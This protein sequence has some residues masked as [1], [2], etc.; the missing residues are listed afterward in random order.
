MKRKTDYLS[1]K[2]TKNISRKIKMKVSHLLNKDF[3]EMVIRMLTKLESGL[4]ELR[5][6]FNKDLLSVIKNQTN[7]KNTI[8][9]I[10]KTH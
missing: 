10:K 7:L 9:E 2:G 3:K 4:E 1:N 5:K 8:T 6:K